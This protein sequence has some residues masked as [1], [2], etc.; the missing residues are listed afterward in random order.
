MP[1]HLIVTDEDATRVITLRRP[2]KKN[3]IT[4]EMYRAMSDAIDTAQNN[5]AIRCLVI[6]GGSGVFTAGND[7]EDFLKDGTS[8]TDAPRASNA[9][10]FLYSLAH[11]V[12]PIIAAVDGVAIGIGTTM[13]FHCDYVLASTTATFSTPFIHLGLV[14]EGA[15]SLLMPRTMG[16]QRA[17]ATLVMGRTVSA[18]AARAS[19]IRRPIRSSFATA[20]GI[21]VL[22]ATARSKRVSWARYTT[23]IPPSPI[24]DSMR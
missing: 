18:D 7:L 8:N 17:F 4:Q 13:L 3:A 12:K 15:S 10:K 21:R 9:T 5:P 20:S 11:N 2:E 24:F 14:P 6:T 22:I 19:W 23:P 16:H 1:G